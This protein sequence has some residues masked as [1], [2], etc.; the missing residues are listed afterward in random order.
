[1][2]K[3]IVKTQYPIQS[4]L[5]NIVFGKLKN[6]ITDDRD[7]LCEIFFAFI[8]IAIYVA[9]VMQKYSALFD[10]DLCCPYLER[11]IRILRLAREP[12][13]KWPY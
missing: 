3:V 11:R 2:L 7:R 5:V 9:L 6:G 1:M 12:Y 13:G 10:A 8:V 4:N